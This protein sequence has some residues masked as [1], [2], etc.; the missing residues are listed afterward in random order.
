MKRIIENK[1]LE[2]VNSTRRKPLIIRGARQVG[3]TWLVENCLA[4]KFDSF[5]K[6]DLESQPQFHSAFEGEL[7]P[8]KMLN[9]I[10]AYTQRITPGKTLLFV[11]EI[12]A[13]PRAIT[14]LRY[15]YEQLPELHVVAA[16]S[17]LEFAFGEISV[18]V[19]RV[20]YLYVLPMTF[21][22]YLLAMGKDAAAEMLMEHPSKHSKGIVKAISEQLRDYFFIGG[23][24]EAVSAYLDTKSNWKLTKS[25]NRFL[26]PIGKIL[27]NTARLLIIHAWTVFLR[28]H[29]SLLVNR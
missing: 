28:R 24:P 7:S 14:A 29:V 4:N 17:M 21:Y 3:K 11:D 9:T 18:P 25:I 15:F 16:G 8:Q 23:M 13:Y 6:I 22:E 19:G 26:H 2:W 20:Q 5:V 27:Q 1:M 10:E 12:Q